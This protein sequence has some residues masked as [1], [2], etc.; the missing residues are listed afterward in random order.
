M[1]TITILSIMRIYAQF[2]SIEAQYSLQALM[3]AA[4]SI[5]PQPYEQLGTTLTWSGPHILSAALGMAVICM[6]YSICSTFRARHG[7]IAA[8]KELKI[9]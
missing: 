9:F 7:H 8:K 3:A 5:R 4:A 1:S 2:Y 6:K